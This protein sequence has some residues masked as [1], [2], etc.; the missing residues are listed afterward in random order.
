MPSTPENAD[1]TP[2][3]SSWLRISLRWLVTAGLVAWLIHKVDF[4]DVGEK[5]SAVNPVWIAAAF[6]ALI[7]SQVASSARWRLLSSACG[8][9]S[10]FGRMVSMYFEGMFASL[11]LPSTVGGDLI[12]VVRLGGKKHKTLAAATVLGDRAAG[13]VALLVLLGIAWWWTIISPGLFAARL[14][15]WWRLG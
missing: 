14:L 13:F 3:K 9:E 10:R 2:S 12:K 7:A 6:L 15:L 4:T 8:L 11:C 1:E 5:L